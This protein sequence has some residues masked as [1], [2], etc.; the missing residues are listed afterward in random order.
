MSIEKTLSKIRENSKQLS[1]LLESFTDLSTQAT[2]AETE[3]LQS[4]LFQMLDLLSVY[5]H[6]KSGAEISPSFNI[7]A[8]V[9][10][11]AEELA[12]VVNTVEKPVTEQTQP[13]PEIKADEASLNKVPEQTSPISAAVPEEKTPSQVTLPPLSVGLNDKF[14][15]INE[16]FLQ[17]ASEYSI[18]IEQLSILSSWQEAEVYLNSLKAVYNWKDTHET[19]KYFVSIV[20]KRY[21]A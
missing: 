4:K 21:D 9:S 11:K 3:A 7:H 6:L 1:E 12:S 17:N 14:R 15:F 19:L 5:K 8:K 16:L 10:K 13:E 18:V 2:A 20:K